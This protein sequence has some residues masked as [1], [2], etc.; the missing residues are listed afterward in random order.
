MFNL[1]IIGFAEQFAKVAVDLL[2]NYFS[3]CV[4]VEE[5]DFGSD[6]FPLHMQYFIW[7]TLRQIRI[8][9]QNNMLCT[10]NAFRC[11]KYFVFFMLFFKLENKLF[12]SHK[13]LVGC[14]QRL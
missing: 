4:K 7:K 5:L 3:L 12:L 8:S 6:F 9:V 10:E 13:M 2:K 1:Q 11:L 14:E